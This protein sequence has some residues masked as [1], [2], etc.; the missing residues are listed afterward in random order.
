MRSIHELRRA[1]LVCGLMAACGFPKPSDIGSD[2]ASNVDV[3]AR[4]GAPDAM[5][6]SVNWFRD[7][8]IAKEQGISAVAADGNGGYYIAGVYGSA[9]FML[10]STTLPTPAQGDSFLARVS[11]GG[12]VIWVQPLYGPG[13]VSIHDLIVD[14]TG[15][16]VVLGAYATDGSAQGPM[17]VGTSTIQ[18]TSL[19]IGTGALF[20]AQFSPQGEARWA[21]KIWGA[22]NYFLHDQQ[23]QTPQRM[24]A[25]PDGSIQL[26]VR[27]PSYVMTGPSQGTENDVPGLDSSNLVLIE[28]TNDGGYAGSY[29][30]ACQGTDA[31]VTALAATNASV[32]Q[33]TYIAGHCDGAID[34]PPNNPRGIDVTPNANGDFLLQVIRTSPGVYTPNGQT[35]LSVVALAID[36]SGDVYDSRV[37]NPMTIERRNATS[38][39]PTWKVT[40]TH[41]TGTSSALALSLD[42]RGN[43]V[44]GDSCTGSI[45]LD[46]SSADGDLTCRGVV[47]AAYGATDGAF[48]W[49]K[50]YKLNITTSTGRWGDSF[51]MRTGA[52]GSILFGA[53][54]NGDIEFDAGLMT[55]NSADLAY[56]L[57]AP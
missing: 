11:A 55:T 9:G 3:D 40:P 1:C 47:F 13:N 14:T 28:L 39:E 36:P 16:P 26:L 43:L 27:D 37:G 35:G 41:A 56:G 46:P 5:P 29:D 51:A 6:G 53:I 52:G 21:V 25:G 31:Q 7:P 17:V 44:T 24:A 8:A 49:A 22:M 54:A 57:L 34:L 10:G 20:V 2:A 15:S 19:N 4:P 42:G 45:S 32:N 38:F 23:V 12:D 48:R 30:V 33:M 50:T 18:L